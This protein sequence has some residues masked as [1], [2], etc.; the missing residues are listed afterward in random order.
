M[1]KIKNVLA[2]LAKSIL[3]SSELKAAASAADAGIYL[4]I[5]ALVTTAFI[6]SN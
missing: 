4:K 5:I 2:L 6:I 3:L 1:P